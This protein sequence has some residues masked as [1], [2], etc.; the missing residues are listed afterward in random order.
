MNQGY[1]T[2]I[3]ITG[4]SPD[5]GYWGSIPMDVLLRGLCERQ[6]DDILDNALIQEYS[7]L[8][9]ELNIPEESK[10]CFLMGY[11]AGKARSRLNA[12][13][14]AMS[15]RPLN[16]D[17]INGFSEVLGRRMEDLLENIFDHEIQNY[18]KEGSVDEEP[19][20]AASR[21]N[22]ENLDEDKIEE[23]PLKTVATI[24]K[25]E[26]EVEEKFSFN[27]SGREKSPHAILGIPVRS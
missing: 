9:N 7:G 27:R 12:C 19:R 15:N 26:E 17:E 22:E 5:G 8:L 10:S 13:S 16:G 25:Q 21:V 2:T 11:I 6:I 14:L 20:L 23:V 18:A 24:R 1:I 4:L 3:N